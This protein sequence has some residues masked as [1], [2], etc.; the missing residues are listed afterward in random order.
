MLVQ[1]L[2]ICDTG[3][4]PNEDDLTAMMMVANVNLLAGEKLD[5]ALKA[6]GADD[7]CTKDYIIP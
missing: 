4:D 6:L 7:V 5:V 1:G 3:V 2:M